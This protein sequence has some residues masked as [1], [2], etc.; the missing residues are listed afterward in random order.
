MDNNCTWGFEGSLDQEPDGSSL[1]V[2]FKEMV[3]FR[4]MECNLQAHDT[5]VVVNF[6]KV[7]VGFVQLCQ[8]L[9]HSEITDGKF[10][11]NIPSAPTQQSGS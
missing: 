4:Y 5:V 8:L 7:H 3:S 10:G 11:D 2:G 1:T 6:D 9:V